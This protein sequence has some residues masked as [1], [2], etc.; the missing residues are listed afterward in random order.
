MSL[1]SNGQLRLQGYDLDLT[2]ATFSNEGQFNVDGDETLT[3][4]TNDPDSGWFYYRGNAS[5]AGLIGGNTYWDLGFN[6][7]AGDWQLG[8]NVDIDNDLY[9][10]NGAF[11]LNGY[12]LDVTGAAFTNNG[13]LK[14]Q[15][16]ETLTNFTNDINSGK[17][18]ILVRGQ[19]KFIVS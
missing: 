3:N 15:G 8:A 9:I 16:G 5:Y 14:L 6:N 11:D 2:G 10:A 19:G 18:F 7:G 13:T 4:F 1:T 17:S 12:D